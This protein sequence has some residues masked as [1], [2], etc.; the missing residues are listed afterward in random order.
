[1]TE[2]AWHADVILPSSLMQKKQEPLLIQI[3]K[4]SW[5]VKQYPHQE[6][7]DKIGG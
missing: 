5:D 1:M 2:T 6:M 7:P 3:V 4:F